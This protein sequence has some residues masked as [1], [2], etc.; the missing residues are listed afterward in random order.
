MHSIKSIF[1]NILKV[2]P[3]QRQSL[4]SLFWQIAIT[5]IGFLSTMYY[6]HTFG[7]AGAAIL[8]AYFL[9]LAYD[10]IFSMLTDG[11]FGGAALKRIS[12]GEEPDAY[13]S[14]YFVLRFSF[15]VIIILILL[16]SK[17]YFTDLVNLD[18]SGMFIWLL[19]DLFL[20]VF[21]GSIASG[22]AGM[23]KI[24]VRN[25]CA[26]I[27]NIMRI[28]IQFVAIYFGYEASGLAGGMVAGAFVAAIIEF[29]FFDL[30]LVRFKWDHIIRLSTFSFWLFL[31]SSGMLVFS[32]ADTVLIG[33]FMEISDVGIYRIVLQFTLVATFSTYAL[34][35]T[36]WPRVSRWG[37]TNEIDLVE[38]SLSRAISYSLVLAMPVLVGG[39][40]LGDRLLYFFY[41]ADFARGYHALIILLCV[42]V[43]NVFQYFFTM[44]LDA[45]DHPKESFKVTAIGIVANIGLN[46]LLIPVIGINGAAIATLATMTLNALLA[47][48]VLSKLMAIR[49]E[50][51]S[52]RNILIASLVMG[53]LV[54]IY[55]W[56]VPLTNLW[57]SLLA[58]VLGGLIYGIV[59]LKLD[60]KI[61]NELR[62]IVEKMGI[63][64]VWPRWL[65][66]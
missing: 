64:F 56:F 42:Q 61:C 16:V 54:G 17:D 32:Y 44:Y 12:E 22:V 57:I 23:S 29:H 47:Q 11:G 28:V 46:I 10:G 53:V 58:V 31:T 25:T 49:L 6:A 2:D 37:K 3:I 27:S 65:L 66:V 13:F 62:E 40:I 19:L 24:G 33:H 18:K 14:A 4:I 39:V 15:T 50:R 26:G 55:R 59:I 43:V 35:N 30:H 60:R 38:E 21:S 51:R 1:S 5:A 63:G 8:G 7:A 48:R 52:I 20:S 41:G 9:F 36:L 45:L 34:R